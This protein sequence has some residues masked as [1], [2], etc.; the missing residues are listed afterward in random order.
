MSCYYD[1][2]KEKI[3]LPIATPILIE[4]VGYIGAEDGIMESANE[5]Q[6]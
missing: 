2:E 1:N 3:K 6:E 5:N 4:L